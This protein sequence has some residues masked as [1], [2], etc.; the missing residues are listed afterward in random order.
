VTDERVALLSARERQV[1]D[2]A[3]QPR[4]TLADVCRELG[5]A[6]GTARQHLHHAYRKLGVTSLGQ[7]ARIVYGE[8]TARS[9]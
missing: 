3:T 6:E 9:V 7:A 8:P 5:I 2:M 4:T 1:L